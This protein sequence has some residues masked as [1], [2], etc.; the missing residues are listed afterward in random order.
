PAHP[1]EGRGVELLSRRDPRGRA[2]AGSSFHY[3]FGLLSR[4]KKRGIEAV[5]AFCRAIDDLADEEPIDADRAARALDLYRAELA[6]CYRGA[7]TLL[8]TR[9]L[10]ST[11]RRFD[12]PPDPFQDLLDGVAMDL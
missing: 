6:L 12:I 7:P 11:I 1:R 3:S 9:D 2:S 4:E 5:Y 10:Q 8:V